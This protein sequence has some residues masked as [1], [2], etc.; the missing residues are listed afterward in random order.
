VGAITIGGDQALTLVHSRVGALTLNETLACTR[1]GGSRGSATGDGTL[2]EG[3][4]MGTQAFSSST[5]EVVSFDV[6]QPDTSYAVLLDWEDTSVTAAVTSRSTSS[7]TIETSGSYTGTVSYT[8][9][10]QLS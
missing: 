7:F 8:V 2:K 5:S 1:I 4:L 6:D 3:L 10:R 9:T